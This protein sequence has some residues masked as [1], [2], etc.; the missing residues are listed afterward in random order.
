MAPGATY[1][2]NVNSGFT[3]YAN[4]PAGQRAASI[5]IVPGVESYE[6]VPGVL[7]VPP[8]GSHDGGAREM[9]DMLD[10]EKDEKL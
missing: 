8:W 7:E 10:A 4:D 6:L 2:F 5:T 1:E 9:F 3:F